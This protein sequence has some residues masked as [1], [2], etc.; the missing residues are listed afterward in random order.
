MAKNS[1]I[2]SPHTKMLDLAINAAKAKG[3]TTSAPSSTSPNSPATSP[4]GKESKGAFDTPPH[5]AN[6]D[7]CTEQ[8]KRW[9]EQ[10]KANISLAQERLTQANSAYTQLKQEAV[11]AF[12]YALGV[13]RAIT[14][15]MNAVS[16]ATE[17]SNVGTTQFMEAAETAKAKCRSIINALQQQSATSGSV[18]STVSFSS[19]TN[20]ADTIRVTPEI[21]HAVSQISSANESAVDLSNKLKPQMKSM[22]QEASDINMAVAKMDAVSKDLLNL[23]VA[24]FH[25]KTDINYIYQQYH[26]AQENAIRMACLIP[27]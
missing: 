13:E 4:F 19:P 16:A 18:A 14:S 25:M 2:D 10:E 8:D 23:G 11:T 1:W 5:G 6:N 20:S 9:I 7:V 27:K 24:L 21:M 15:L 3:A 26:V 22:N 12:S 17:N